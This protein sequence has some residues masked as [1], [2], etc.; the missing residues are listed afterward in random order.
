M[1]PSRLHSRID[2]FEFQLKKLA[3]LERSRGLL[4]V[5]LVAA[6][7]ALVLILARTDI[8]STPLRYRRHPQLLLSFFL[9]LVRE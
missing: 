1:I 8:T 9:L 4:H 6:E 2:R 7:D 5:F 3:Y